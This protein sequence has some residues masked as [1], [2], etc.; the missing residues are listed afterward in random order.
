MKRVDSTLKNST[1]YL[2]AVAH[3]GTGNRCSERV[4]QKSKNPRVGDTHEVY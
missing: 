2:C 4:L 1:A 3:P